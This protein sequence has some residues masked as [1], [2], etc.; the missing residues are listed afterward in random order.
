MRIMATLIVLFQ[1]Q[2][3][4]AVLLTVGYSMQVTL[5]AA[6]V[7]A[8]LATEITSRLLGGKPGS[9]PAEVPDGGSY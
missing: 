5:T 4:V 2:L 9:P 1:V 3:F 8:V 7:V 6:S